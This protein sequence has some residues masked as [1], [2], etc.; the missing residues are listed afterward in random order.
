MCGIVGCIGKSSNPE[1]TYQLLTNLLIASQVRGKHATGYYLVDE[2]GDEHSFKSPIPA[3]MFV[4]TSE[5]KNVEALDPKAI[6]MHARFKT[7]G[8]ETDSN[9]NHPHISK[10]KN[11]ALVHNGSLYDSQ[12][13]RKDY[14]LLG[15]TDSELI[16]KIILKANNVISGIQEV[17]KLFGKSGDF[18]CEVIYRNP[19]TKK[20]TFY[21][22]K[23]SG[24][25]GKVIN[26]KHGLGQYFFCSTSGI[27]AKAY[28]MLSDEHKAQLPYVTAK[29]V[30]S[31]QI[32]KISAETLK[33]KRTQ[34]EVPSKRKTKPNSNTYKVLYTVPQIIYTK[35]K[36]IYK[37]AEDQNTYDEKLRMQSLQEQH[38][39]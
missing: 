36:N 33:I 23:D 37:Y 38:K 11:I 6:I 35:G 16:L 29:N 22:F 1:L 7:R 14:H 32:W 20:P 25:P 12:Q 24:R 2:N 10:T 5:W 13:Y 34:L 39:L 8:S 27:W 9:N 21:F 17:F 30:P 18:A 28:S 4:T 31:F 3:S 26:L 19:V 15:E